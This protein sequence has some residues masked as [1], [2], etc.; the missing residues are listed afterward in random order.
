MSALLEKPAAPATVR[1]ERRTSPGQAPAEEPLGAHR[2]ISLVAVLGLFWPLLSAWGNIVAVPSGGIAVVALTGGAIWLLVA[3]ATART[4]DGLAR[5]DRWL[6]ALALLVLGAWAAQKLNGAA[7]YGTDEASFEQGAANL[8]VHGHDPYGA[9]LLPTLA[10]FS[11]PTKYMTYTM[12]GGVVS[13]FGYP[14]LP[15]LVVAPFVE[16]TGGGQAVPIA[17][18][19]VLMV[20]TVILYLQ[21]PRAWRGLA[22][23]LCVGYP[24]LATFAFIGV[25]VIM[26]T[27]ALLVVAHRWTSVGE[28]GRLT[29]G[30]GLRALALGLALAT[31]QLAWFIAPFLL[32]GIF[33]ARR[34]HLGSRPARRL[35]L[36]Y[37]GIAVATF[38]V[39][40]APFFLWGPSAWLHGVAA[41]LTQ[42]AIPYGQGIVGLT[43]FLRLGGGLLDAYNYAAGLLYVALLVLY[44]ARFR[45]LGRA[46]FALPLV[47]LFFSGRSLA[48]YWLTLIAV[49]AISVISADGPTIRSVP[50]L[51][52]LRRL[53]R[54]A[55]RV[56]A[57]GLF[58]PA[59]AC[60]ALALGTPQPLTVRILVAHSS[61]LLRSVD[62]LRLLVHNNSEEPLQPHFATNVT[63]Q[64]ILWETTRGPKTLAPGSDAVYS[65]TAP[66]A[67]SMPANATPFVVEAVTGAPRTISSSQR[68]TQPG[69]VPGYW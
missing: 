53:S 64:A 29:R 31:N 38:A 13:T 39:I 55:Q 60:L 25:N 44:V 48:E 43:L 58:L 4:E 40:N 19:F 63:G 45:T 20:A 51:A 18:V 47:A 62:R 9:N 35:T 28:S 54:P 66:D 10:Q 42:H 41:P 6:L 3:I 21:L 68:F 57:V 50:P 69:Q 2:A 61:H 26:A 59:A 27:T 32:S 23:V 36:G 7:G 49:V 37:L 15:L 8:L 65:L 11:T 30:D 24:I 12:T 34:A 46:A 14:A 52:A 56:V 1:G 67:S 16:L 17:D 5:L 33:L 22:V